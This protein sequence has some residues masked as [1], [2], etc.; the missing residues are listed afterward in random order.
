[1]AAQQNSFD[2][3]S[4][5]NMQ[6]VRNAVQIAVKE[7]QTRFDFKGSNSTIEL[8]EDH[9]ELKTG[10]EFLLKSLT[11]LLEEKMVKRKVTVKSFTYGTVEK[12][13]GGTVRQRI[14]IQQGIPI[15]KAREIVKLIKNSK[16]RVQ[17]A[18]Q[19]D[20]V[21]V[22]GRDRDELQKV[23]QLLRDTDF[24]V[25]LQFTNYRTL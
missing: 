24:G 17:S 6:E 19:S 3:V 1:M 9:I 10:D 21:R 4:E 14:S 15:E 25:P 22:S 11:Q 7:V 13:L 8:G 23:I 2:V 20:T 18:I 16:L 12:A 5:V